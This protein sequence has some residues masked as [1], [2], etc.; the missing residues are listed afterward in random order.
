MTM[1]TAF[2]LATYELEDFLLAGLDDG[3]ELLA[4]NR[5]GAAC[6]GAESEG[7]VGLSVLGADRAMLTLQLFGLAG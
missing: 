2:D 7:L 5:V 3:V 4:Q 6:C 1:A